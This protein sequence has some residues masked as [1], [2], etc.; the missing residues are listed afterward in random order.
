M[1]VRRWTPAVSYLRAEHTLAAAAMRLLELG[2]PEASRRAW[3]ACL[4]LAA[5]RAGTLPPRKPSDDP[6]A[7]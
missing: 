2:D 1:T 7:T 5:L 3:R 6:T 4:E